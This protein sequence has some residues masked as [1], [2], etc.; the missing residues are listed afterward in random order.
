MPSHKTPAE[1]HASPSHHL[2]AHLVHLQRDPP[3]LAGPISHR[4]RPI[5]ACPTGNGWENRVR[6]VLL[7]ILVHQAWYLQGTLVVELGIRGLYA[8]NLQLFQLVLPS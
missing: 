1:C 5:L 6:W 2:R 7:G 4:C 3:M 8:A